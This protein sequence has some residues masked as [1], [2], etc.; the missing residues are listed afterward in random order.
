MIHD[1]E[2][3]SSICVKGSRCSN[4]KIKTAQSGKNIY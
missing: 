1:E 3:R 4:A 2:L